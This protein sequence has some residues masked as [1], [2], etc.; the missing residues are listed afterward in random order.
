MIHP[1]Y[2]L[3]NAIDA[4]YGQYHVPKRDQQSLRDMT[5]MYTGTFG[6]FLNTYKPKKLVHN[7]TQK[8]LDDAEH[9]FWWESL[10]NIRSTSPY[11]GE[12]L[13]DAIDTYFGP[14]HLDIPETGTCIIHMRVGDMFAAS[15][16]EFQVDFIVDATDKLPERP[17]RFEILNGGRYHD[18]LGLLE[19]SNNSLENLMNRLKIKFPESEVVF[20]ESHNADYEFFRMV[21]APMLITGVGSFSVLAALVN[22]NF[23]L[24]PALSC[25]AGYDVK[26]VIT[27][28]IISESWY[29]YDVSPRPA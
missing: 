12:S 27:P 5:L 29:T 19:R 28:G 20:F 23:R 8:F 10:E 14:K 7:P 3:G 1:S 26:H 4:W 9:G 16:S 13:K 15:R 11:F 2:R 17:K 22:T 6:H 21:H 18:H 24:S 25:F